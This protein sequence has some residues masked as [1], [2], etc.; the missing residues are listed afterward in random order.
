MRRQLLLG[1]LLGLLLCCAAPTRARA[2]LSVTF[3]DVGQGDGALVTSPTGKRVLIDGGPPPAGPQLVQKLQRRGVQ[4][5]DMILLTHPHLDHLGGLEQVVRAL[6]VRLFMDSG[7]PH[8]SP[9]YSALL[10]ALQARGVPLRQASAGRKIDLGDGATLQL[11]GPPSP[12]LSGTRSDVNANS[13]VALLTWRGARALLTGD[14][15]PETEA[16]LQ[17]QGAIPQAE[18][19]KVA[20]HGGRFSSTAP[21]L[22]A[23]A[24]KL[25]VISVAAHNDY[26]HPTPAALSRLAAVGARVYRTDLLGDV[27]ARSDGTGWSVQAEPSQAAP[28]TPAPPISAPAQTPAQAPAQAPATSPHSGPTERVASQR[29]DVFHLPD[30]GAVQRIKPDNLIRFP[31]RE[32]ALASGRRPAGD[33]HP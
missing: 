9:A 4:S 16:W 20:H 32:A 21:F 6:P 33:C 28:Q 23:V 3:F 24:P 19:L 14:S 22:R 30:C 13:V 18:L 2:D 25:A 31:S 15:E 7:F 26:G 12:Y 27:T 29:S 5:L 1:L 17:Q 8:P 10:A 11:L